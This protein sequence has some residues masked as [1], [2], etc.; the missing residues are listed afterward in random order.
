MARPA[1]GPAAAPCL[2][3]SLLVPLMKLAQSFVLANPA[4]PDCPIVYASARFLALTGHPRNSRD[5][6]QLPLPA[7]ARPLA[8]TIPCP[9]YVCYEVR[10]YG[11]AGAPPGS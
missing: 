3:T 4:L 8:L 5:R 11:G 2:P 9:L 1:A 6:P 10:L 7:G